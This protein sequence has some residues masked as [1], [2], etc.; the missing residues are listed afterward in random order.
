MN[1]SV[2]AGHTARRLWRRAAP[3]IVVSVFY[4][5]FLIYPVLRIRNLILPEPAG[6]PELLALMVIPILGRLV[7]EWYQAP[8][9]RW[10]SALALT[11]LGI[12]FIAFPLVVCWEFIDLF[13]RLDDRTAGFTLL[14][15]ISAT[16]LVAIYNAQMPVVKAVAIPAPES[17]QGTT[18]AQISDVHVGSR[19]GRFLQRVV[20]KVNASKP[21]YV[22]ITGDLIDFRDITVAE[23]SSLGDL[24][25][26]V[27]LVIGNH[28]RYVD[29][30]AICK[31]LSSLGVHVLRNESVN[32]GEFQLLGIDDNESK[33]QVYRVL[34]QLEAEPDKFRILLYHRPDGAVDAAQWGVDLMLCGHT[35]NGQIVPFNL[36]VRRF[37]SRICGL[38]TVE[39]LHLY[40]SAG[41]G[42]WGP[43]LRLGSRCEIGM[44]RL[45]QQ[46]R[47]EK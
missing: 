12:S 45:V 36:L 4:F 41:T 42:T 7:Y 21:D 2:I 22:L 35:H 28:E 32:M 38:Y 1:E 39:Q 25:A 18:F 34:D 11:W 10:L 3:S 6:T 27:Y 29:L 26:P 37:F 14:L 16:A 47:I 19:S 43:T 44:I 30:A 31:R 20:A 15:L 24:D 40:V 23:L 46:K 33:S 9:T 13:V 8:W 17:L 5:G